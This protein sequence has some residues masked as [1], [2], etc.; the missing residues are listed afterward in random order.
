MLSTIRHSF[1]TFLILLLF[2]NHTARANSAAPLTSTS[3]KAATL[4]IDPIAPDTLFPL[5][6]PDL[7]HLYA[8]NDYKPFWNT[9]LGPTQK[10]ETLLSVLGNAHLDGLHPQDYYFDLLT[11]LWKSRGHHNIARL[12]VLLT[13]GLMSF[14]SDIKTGRTNSCWLNPQLSASSSQALQISDFLVLINKALVTDDLKSFLHSQAPK[15]PQYLRLRKALTRYHSIASKGGWDRIDD[16]P[17]IRPGDGDPRLI[18][19]G[20]RLKISGDLDPN[21]P[22][23]AEYTPELVLG[24][25]RFQKRFNLKPDGIIG[26]ETFRALNIPVEELVERIILNMERWRWLAENSTAKKLIINIAGFTLT[27]MVDE[28]VT[29]SMPVIVG[30]VENKTPVFNDLMRYIVFN[31]YWNI[32][33][34]IA[35][36][37][38]LPK[39]INDATYLISNNIRMFQGWEEGA[40]EVQPESIDW[41][42]IGPRIGNYRFRQE[43][44]PDNALG[45]IKFMFPNPYNIYLHDT[46]APELFSHHKRSF[47]HGCVRVSAPDT[48]ALF[49]LK[50][51]GTREWGITK[52]EKLIASGQRSVIRLQQPV[53]VHIVYRTVSVAAENDTTYF[54]PDIY[55]RDKA[56][57]QSL[58]T[59]NKSRYCMFKTTPTTH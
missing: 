51:P 53:P 4:A 38:I 1:L 37:E 42:R 16:G 9:I 8:Q 10:A 35:R 44:G 56:L 5:M 32:P 57:A 27:G 39:Q 3:G 50:N 47:S 54:Y 17:V 59:D 48:L 55:G 41:Q 2:L 28:E 58:F 19:I 23:Y 13:F 34:S 45:R 36:E 7:R 24:I 25:E 49:L 33:Q 14:L 40:L 46:S 11:L 12:D 20:K 6:T 52:I 21:I 31:P 22:L 43:P 29:L 30:K 26:R 15:Y 18:S